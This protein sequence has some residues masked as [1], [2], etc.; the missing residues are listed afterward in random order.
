MNFF[1]LG[2]WAALYAYT[3]EAYPTNLRASGMGAATGYARIAGV[4]AP[5]AG[6]ALLSVSLVSALSMF[7][8][9]FAVAAAVV[10][11]YASETRGTALGDTV[12]E[13]EVVGAR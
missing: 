13:L 7:A 1:S 2:A 11:W 6:G 3:P 12:S 8:A 10:A 5:L 9:S 4:V